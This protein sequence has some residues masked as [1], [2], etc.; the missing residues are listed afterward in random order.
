MF[1]CLLQLAMQGLNK[2]RNL[3]DLI[4]AVVRDLRHNQA[5][6]EQLTTLDDDQAR[7]IANSLVDWIYMTLEDEKENT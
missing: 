5:F 1:V 3:L 7:K 2:D 4:Q 6:V